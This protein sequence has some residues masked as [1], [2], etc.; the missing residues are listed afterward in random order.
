MASWLLATSESLARTAMEMGVFGAVAAKSSAA[1]G[2][3]ACRV[4]PR[5]RKH[6]QIEKAFIRTPKIEGPATASQLSLRHH[7]PIKASTVCSCGSSSSRDG[8]QLGGLGC[9]AGKEEI[10][11]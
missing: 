5:T 7:Q 1:V 8:A 9:R 6:R 2:A 10:G 4:L 11:K 3:S